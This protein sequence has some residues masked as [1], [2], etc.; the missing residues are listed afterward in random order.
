[1]KI[2]L[3]PAALL[4]RGAMLEVGTA[5]PGRKARPGYRWVQ[6]W[7]VLDPRT[8]YWSHVMRRKY[9]LAEAKQIIE[10]IHRADLAAQD[11]TGPD[12]EAMSPTALRSPL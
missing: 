6:G 3:K 2:E 5:G 10:E 9:A 1:M 7:E 12:E 11:N 8:G 4:R